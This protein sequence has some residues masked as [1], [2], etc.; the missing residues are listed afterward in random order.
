MEEAGLIEE[1][2]GP[3]PWVSNLVLTHKPN[4]GTRVT[5]DMLN[6]NKAIEPTNIPIPIR[7]QSETCRLP[8]VL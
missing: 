7:S 1:H 6:M 4:G 8:V 5:V 2:H 3:A